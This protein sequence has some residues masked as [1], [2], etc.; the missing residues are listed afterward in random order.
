MCETVGNAM[1]VMVAVLALLQLLSRLPL[2][3]SVSQSN[4]P[5]QLGCLKPVL[6]GCKLQ[7]SGGRDCLECVSRGLRTCSLR[8]V[9]EFAAAVCRSKSAGSALSSVSAAI[10]RSVAT[11]DSRQLGCLSG[12]LMSCQTQRSCLACA[13]DAFRKCGLSPVHAVGAGLCNSDSD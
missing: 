13:K 8:Q 5:G 10:F 7:Q 2:A 12:T 3:A 11:S 1:K 6:T 9:S 4:L